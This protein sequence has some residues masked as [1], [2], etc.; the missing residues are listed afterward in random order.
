MP[1]DAFD[2]H[3][4]RYAQPARAVADAV[5]GQNDR[6]KIVTLV[7]MAVQHAA[8]TV[9]QLAAELRA[10]PQ[11]GS[12]GLRSVLSEVA[13]GI[14]TVAEADFARLVKRSGLPEPMYNVRL[15]V[16]SQF[17]A[18]ADAWWPEAGVVA[19]VD[20]REWHL[21]PLDWEKTMARHARM[22]AQGILVLHFSPRQIHAD[23]RLV[24]SELRAALDAGKRRPKLLIGT[25]QVG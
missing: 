4:V 14:S 24:V 17:L 25:G 13:V 12:S 1:A 9:E 22:S 23:P 3:G 11:R 2:L 15:Y 5:R 19:E 10:G 16:G 6:G 21:S 8:C 7:G 20:S 18:K